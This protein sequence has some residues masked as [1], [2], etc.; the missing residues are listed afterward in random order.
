[1]C[2]ELLTA[3]AR[4]ELTGDYAIIC[5]R[6]VLN[7]LDDHQNET[8]V[9]LHIAGTSVVLLI[10]LA[11][12]A[13][14]G[15][16]VLARTFACYPLVSCCTLHNSVLHIAFTLTAMCSV[17]VFPNL[18]AVKCGQVAFQ[19]LR[20]QDTGIGEGLV[21]LFVFF[22]TTRFLG[23]STR[24]A[25]A[26]LFCGYF[27]AWTGHFFFEGNRPATFIYPT[28]S[29]ICDLLLWAETVTGITITL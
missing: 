19:L 9:T 26:V 8:S 24:V 22:T 21:V 25:L 23:G 28:Y 12:P 4:C 20:H 3:K 13:L 10:T 2:W 11:N 18:V 27:C 16:A 5:A 29:L 15:S 7:S 1:M 17:C 6:G 14:F